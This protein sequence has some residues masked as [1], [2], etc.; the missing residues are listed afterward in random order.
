MSYTLTHKI[1][2]QQFHIWYH[3]KSILRIPLYLKYGKQC[4]RE[5]VEVGKWG[6][7]FEVERSSK[8]LHSQQGKDENEQEEQEQQ[9]DDGP[10]GAQQRDD[11]IAE[12]RPV[13][14]EGDNITLAVDFCYCM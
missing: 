11:E 14:G 8:E 13:S 2:L 7:V 9:G 5:G 10:H 1:S 6:L 12:W 4:Y 3:E